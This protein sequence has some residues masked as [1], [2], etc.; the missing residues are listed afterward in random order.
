MAAKKMKHS[1]SYGATEPQ[2]LYDLWKRIRGVTG[3]KNHPKYHD[4]GGRGIGMYEPWRPDFPKFRSWM[5]ENLGERPTTGHSL[6]RIDVNKGYKPG[7]I[8]WA[9]LVQQARNQRS[10][11]M[12]TIG[13][14]T[15]C[16]MEWCELYGRDVKL[17]WMR[18]FQLGWD[19]LKALETPPRKLTRKQKAAMLLLRIASI[20]VRK[21]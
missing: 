2:Y 13:K 12:V 5:L 19:P 9:T 6:D 7:N 17:A 16:L 15:K 10:N 21:L 8:Q 11:R 18:I 20:L 4:Y 3:N 14:K 1:K